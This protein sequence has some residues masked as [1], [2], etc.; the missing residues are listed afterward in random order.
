MARNI[1]IAGLGNPG[2]EY[3]NTRHNAGFKALDLIQ[4][5]ELFSASPWKMM[6]NFYAEVSEGAYRTNRI[7]LVKPQTFMNLSGKSI[8]LLSGFYKIKPADIWVVYDDKDLKM[9]TLRIRDMG[10]TG[11]HNG[12]KSIAELI[13]T[14]EFGR[15]RLGIA[16]ENIER[17]DTSRFVLGHLSSEEDLELEEIIKKR[18]IPAIFKALDADLK[19]AQAS[20][21]N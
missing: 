6:K 2:K 1:L 16:T 21:G 17:M 13:G 3:E 7:Y 14:L 4:Q 10:S 11:G 5:N 8:A 12:I 20:F 9:G 18:L 15:F 19:S